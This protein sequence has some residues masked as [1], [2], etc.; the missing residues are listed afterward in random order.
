[1]ASA[2]T[3]SARISLVIDRAIIVAATVATVTSLAILFVTLM[4]EVILR[5]FTARSLGW[6]NEMP[7]LLYPWLAMGGAVLAAQRGRHIAVTL[8]QELLPVAVT[9]ALLIVLHLL[10]AAGF[11][12]LAW[13]GLTVLQVAGGERY[14]VSRISAY[15]AYL[16]LVTGFTLIAVTAVT[17][18]PRVLLEDDPVQARNEGP[19]VQ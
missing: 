4:T 11:L 17:S 2:L 5:Y 13:I 1:M 16:A 18:L 19:E 12:Y 15:W 14:P 6:P 9:R 3:L 8:L 7:A 10:A